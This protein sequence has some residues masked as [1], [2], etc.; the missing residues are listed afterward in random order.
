MSAKNKLTNQLKGASKLYEDF[1]G[2]DAEEVG[3]FK[4]PSVPD[5]LVLIGEVDG[6]MYRTV[7]DGELELY[8]HRFKAAARP[9]FA[10]SPNGKQIFLLGG[11]Y[12]FTERGIVD[13]VDH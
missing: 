2:H 4:K 3:R 12:D 13:D 9:M 10:V 8:V 11:R 5:V 6:I 1:S 7:R